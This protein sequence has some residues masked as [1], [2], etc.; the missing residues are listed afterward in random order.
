MGK[1]LKITEDQLKRLV[2]NKDKFQ[3]EPVETTEEEIVDLPEEEDDEN[4]LNESV[5]VYKS[6]FDRYLK[7]PKQ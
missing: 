2:E 7:G 3:D 6:E 5:K 1:K 4:Q